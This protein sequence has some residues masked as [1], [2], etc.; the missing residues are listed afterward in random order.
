MILNRYATLVLLMSLQFIATANWTPYNL[1][2]SGHKSMTTLNGNLYVATTNTGIQKSINGGTSWTLANTGLPLTGSDIKVQ[3]VGSNAT[4]LF[5]GTESGIYRSTDNGS[6]W[7]LANGTLTASA[8]VFA[9]K[10]YNYGGVTFAVFSGMI[11]QSSGGIFRTVNN[12]DTWLAAFSGLSSNMTIYNIAEMN[13]TLY[14]STSTALMKSTDLG[15]SWSQVGTTNYA[16]YAVAGAYGRLVAL[17]T[18]GARYS[19]D[20]GTIWTNSTNYPVAS[21]AAGSELIAYDGKYYAITKSGSIG[22]QRSLDGGATWEAF[23]TGLSIQN[24][25]AQEEFHAN[26]NDL[27][28]V[29]AL[30][31]HS[32]AAT[33]VGTAEV[34]RNTAPLIRPTLF[35][36]GFSID[37]SAENAGGNILLLD[38]AGRIAHQL[39]NA[40]NTVLNIDRNGLANGMYQVVLVDQHGASM[41]LLG[42][43]IAQ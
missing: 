9:N 4:T 35:T 33:S 13:G 23:N 30:D 12:G 3:S 38:A 21:P 36:D 25:F 2:N 14:A 28:I 37:L 8:T 20:G 16:V 18:F 6:S 24:T 32:T 29:C 10:F 42:K 43:V 7:A 40:P 27:F 26:G 17:T 1:T 19:V 5:C 15:Q 41:R 39:T 22:C 11:S 31:I 34:A